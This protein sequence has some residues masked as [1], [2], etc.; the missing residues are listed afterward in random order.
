M[1][2]ALASIIN[3]YFPHEEPDIEKVP[4]GLTNT[5]WFVKGNG[6]TYVARHYNRYT[7]SLNSLDLEIKVTAFLEQSDLSF[8]I[9]SFLAT[10]Q[11]DQYVT[12]SDGSL[13]AVI[14]FIAGKAPKLDTQADAYTLGSVVGELSAKLEKYKGPESLAFQGIPFTD[15]YRLHPLAGVE[16]IASFWAQPP[17]PVTDV[18]KQTYDQIVA[19]VTSQL[20]ALLTLPRQLV[21]HDVLVY[22][23]LAVDHRITGVLDFDFIGLDIGSLDFVISLNHVL[24]LS[25]GSLQMAEAFIKGHANFRTFTREELDH[26][27]TLTRLYHIALLHIYIGQHRA[28]KDI[29]EAFSYI[30]DQF[31]ERDRWLAEHGN[32]LK[33]VLSNVSKRGQ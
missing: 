24:Q 7:K 6:R 25:G 31:I 19:S 5:T 32:E 21:H 13:G 9:P 14:S 27:R 29:A 10:K 26:L 23:L 17:F 30:I 12:L 16:E 28:G 3:A 2:D 8:E 11:G 22:N 33:R 18:Q 20:D 1:V 15:L 4:Y